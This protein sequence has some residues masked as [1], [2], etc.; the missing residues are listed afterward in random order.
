MDTSDG[1]HTAI[2]YKPFLG[3]VNTHPKLPRARVHAAANHEAVTW[4]EDMQGARHGWVSH[5][6]HKDRHILRQIR[7]LFGL[8]QVSFSPLGILLAQ[9]PFDQHVQDSC[10]HVLPTC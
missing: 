2:I 3:I 9:I 4:L 8:L 7:K 1:Q 5:G 10:H 6:T